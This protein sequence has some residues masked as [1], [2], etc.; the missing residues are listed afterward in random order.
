MNPIQPSTPATPAMPV[1]SE[2]APG[3]SPT[4]VPTGRSWFT[5]GR[6]VALAL[7][8]TIAS[9]GASYAF[10]LTPAGQRADRTVDAVS[11]RLDAGIESVD[12]AI[13]RTL[14]D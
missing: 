1:G 11:D 8:L 10:S 6:V 13:E 3:Q 5:R 14:P 4:G 9:S 7:A 12:D 2:P